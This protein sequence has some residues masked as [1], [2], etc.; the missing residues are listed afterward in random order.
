MSSLFWSLPC[1]AL[2]GAAVLSVAAPAE[3]QTAPPSPEPYAGS[4]TE[5]SEEGDLE[6][7]VVQATR[8]GRRVQDEPIRVEVLNR[9]EIEEKILMRPGNVAMLLSETG[10][11]RVQ[12]TS[13]GLGSSNV[14]VQG[15]EGRYTQLLG[16]GLPLY[17]G[18]SLGLLQVAPTD[19]GQVEVIKGA[20][21]ALYGPSAL[22]GVIN[23]VSR[24]P[25]PEAEA[26]ALLNV[27]SRGGQDLTLYGDTPLSADWRASITGGAHRQDRK[28]LD[29]DG[30]VDTPGYGRLTVRPRLF[31]SGPND[32]TA[33]VTLGA[34]REDRRGGTLPGRTVPDGRA[35]TESQDSRRLDGGLVAS[36]PVEQ[37]GTVQVRASAMTQKD[38]HRFGEPWSRTI[39]RTRCSPRRPSASPPNDLLARGALS[40]RIPSA[41][42]ASPAST[43]TTR[44]RPC[45]RRW[46]TTCARISPWRAAPGPTLIVSTERGRAPACR[47]STVPAPGRCALRSA[48]A[49][50]RRRRSSRRWRRPGWRVW[51]R[52]T[53]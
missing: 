21:S 20:A 48:A 2:L 43:T 17:G 3:A 46:S 51:S 5:T 31:W 15:M 50:T 7:I 24:R 9:E 42:G 30:W 39:A 33:Y 23:L 26:E 44:R 16:D 18:Q 27:T 1:R 35:F 25:G 53:G 52:S 11:L 6:T 12:V 38:H 8:S 47:C 10:G 37:L 36:V 49:S 4:A 13:P 14:R 41:R 22:G 32:A 45:S 19:L 28:D 34:M 40:R 29:G